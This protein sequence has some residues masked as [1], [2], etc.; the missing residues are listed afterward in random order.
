MITVGFKKKRSLFRYSYFFVGFP[1]VNPTYK[2][3]RRLGWANQWV[4]ENLSIL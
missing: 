1:Y 3:V 2:R 4:K